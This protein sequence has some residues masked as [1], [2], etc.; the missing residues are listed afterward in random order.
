MRK[1]DGK[2][3][4]KRKQKKLD[5]KKGGAAAAVG[6]TVEMGSGMMLPY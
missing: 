1:G 3:A 5:K 2:R 6:G 4:E